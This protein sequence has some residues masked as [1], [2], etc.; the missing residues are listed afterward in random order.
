MCYINIRKR[1]PK[2]QLT[3]DNPEALATL[4]TRDTGRK[5]T[6]HKHTGRKQTKHKHTGRKQTKHK[7]T[8]QKT[9]KMSNTDPTKHQR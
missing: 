3:I 6:K 8:T 1:K 7:H 2:G 9:K 4:G 5:Q